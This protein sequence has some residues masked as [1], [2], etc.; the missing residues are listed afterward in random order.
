MMFYT[1]NETVPF[2]LQNCGEYC[3]LEDYSNELKSVL[4]ENATA[5]CQLETTNNPNSSPIPTIDTILLFI[6]LIFTIM[7]MT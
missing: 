1:Y 5:L 2:H 3:L 6:L 7:N 4:P